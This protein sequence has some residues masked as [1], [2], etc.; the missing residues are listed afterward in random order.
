M[1]TTRRQILA[2]AAE[3]LFDVS[4]MIKDKKTKKMVQ[5]AA[6]DIVIV[7]EAIKEVEAKKKRKKKN[8]K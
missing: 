1:R 7:L 2:C 8:V 4:D 3:I 6:F 5:R